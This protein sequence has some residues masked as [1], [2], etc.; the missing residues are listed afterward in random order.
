MLT[1]QAK[2]MR[3]NRPPRRTN[4]DVL[5]PHRYASRKNSPRPNQKIVSHIAYYNKNAERIRYTYWGSDGII[6]DSSCK[7]E[8]N[9]FI[10]C[11]D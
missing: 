5:S 3:V 10:S 11:Y 9:N 7:D 2:L 4:L 6:L 1:I 8:D